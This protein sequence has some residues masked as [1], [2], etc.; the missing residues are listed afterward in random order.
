MNSKNEAA[1]QLPL[2]TTTTGK[3]E[4]KDKE[5]R[6]AEVGKREKQDDER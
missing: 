1:H 5:E 2:I 6:E 4:D 3:E